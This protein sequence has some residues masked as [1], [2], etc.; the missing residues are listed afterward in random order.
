M[1]SGPSTGRRQL[2]TGSNRALNAVL[3]PWSHCLT[4]R[5]NCPRSITDGAPAVRY[6]GNVFT[7]YSNDVK[8]TLQSHLCFCYIRYQNLLN[9]N[10]ARIY[11]ETVRDGIGD[12]RYRQ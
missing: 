7:V 9:G 2:R 6:L 10:F 3:P 5:G 8:Y 11:V 1:G 12:R 4:P